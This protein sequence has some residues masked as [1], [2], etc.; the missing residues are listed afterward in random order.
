MEL[1]NARNAQESIPHK[2]QAQAEEKADGDVQQREHWRLRKKVEVAVPKRE[3]SFVEQDRGMDVRSQM[4][5][6]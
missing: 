2:S 6:N 1:T 5:V 3:A 4:G